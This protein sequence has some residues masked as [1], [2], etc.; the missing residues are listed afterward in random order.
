MRPLNRALFFFLA[1]A[2]I[3]LTSSPASADEM[4]IRSA[5]QNSAGELVLGGSG[6]RQGVRVWLDF[7]ELQVLSVNEREVHVKMPKLGPGTYRLIADHSRSRATSFIVAVGGAAGSGTG[8]AGPQGPV[9]PQGPPGPAGPRGLTGATGATGAPGAAGVT[10]ATGATGATGPA[11]P[12]GPPGAA[13]GGLSVYDKNGQLVGP[14]VGV[15]FGGT[16]S[17]M[18]ARQANDGVWLGIPVDVAGVVPGAAGALLGL[19]NDAQCSPPAFVPADR[20][21][22]TLLRSLQRSDSESTAYYAGDPLLPN[23]FAS[24]SPIGHPEICWSTAGTGW[25]VQL[26]AGPLKTFDLSPFVP[27]FSVK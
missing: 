18:V 10:G 6:F 8:P 1:V 19:Y 15:K 20:A 9:G 21:P 11:G 17:T 2:M 16:D 3:G 7:G 25:D 24:F 13:G 4:Y 23:T 27:P 14:I 26:L 12:Q 22:A 5:H